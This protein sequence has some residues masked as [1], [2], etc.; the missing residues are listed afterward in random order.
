[1]NDYAIG[2]DLGGTSIRFGVICADG[3]LLHR[4]SILTRVKAGPEAVVADMAMGVREMVDFLPAGARL[5]G[6]GVGSPGPINL[7]DGVLG[8][9]PN[10]PGWENYPL[11]D[12]LHSATSLPVILESD[13]NA[14]ALAEWQMGLDNPHDAESSLPPIRSMCMITL[15]TGVGSGLI[16]DGSIWHGIL[17]MGGE[18]GHCSID[19]TGERCSCGNRGCLELYASATG[20]VQAA[21][22]AQISGADESTFTTRDLASLARAGSESAGM[23]FDRVGEALGRAITTLINTLDLELY[24]I[25]GGV[26]RAWDLFAPAMFSLL[27]DR[28]VVYR[29][30]KPTQRT[31]REH[32]RPFIISASLGADSGLIGAA[33][34]PILHHAGSV[35]GAVAPNR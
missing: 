33:L 1:M 20:I 31:Q 9:L 12:A 10:F 21:R 2:I 22:A 4:N 13:A 18:V 19:P 3:S 28:S 6:I 15:G 5:R 34:L 11:R 26:S 32:D 24:V 17:G 23:I 35:S 7:R 16:L 25:G 8:L 30:N 29:L 14:A 27:E